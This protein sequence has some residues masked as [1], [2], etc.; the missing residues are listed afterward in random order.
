MSRFWL[1]EGARARDTGVWR[2]SLG[3]DFGGLDRCPVRVSGDR[4]GGVSAV[5]TRG[6]SGA[7]DGVTD[8]TV[9]PSPPYRA[10]RVAAGVSR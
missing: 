7:A 9:A 10:V 2:E 1:Q 8:L 4:V 3:T 5:H 6:L